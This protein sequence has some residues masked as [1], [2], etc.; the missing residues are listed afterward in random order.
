MEEKKVA[1]EWI[2]QG[3][4][5]DL[6]IDTVILPDGNRTTREVVVHQGAVAIVAVTE[7]EE[8]LLVKQFRYP[9]GQVLLEIPAGKLEKGEDPLECA[10][11]ELSEETGCA[12]EEWQPISTFYTTP[13]FS[14]EIMHLYL[15][16][17]LYKNEQTADT[18]E[19]IEVQQVSLDSAVQKVFSGEIK[20]AKSIAGI[21][22]TRL[23]LKK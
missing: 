10:K 23:V 3:I 22:L 9:V 4:I 5:L 7:A 21:L 16:K 14:D 13:G 11:R 15:A 20:D 8:I 17:K 1:G 2:Y 18:D 12:A 19:F 6:K